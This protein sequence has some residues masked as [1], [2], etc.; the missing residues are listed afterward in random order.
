[1]HN[2]L[3]PSRSCQRDPPPRSCLPRRHHSRHRNTSPRPRLAPRPAAPAAQRPPR[4]LPLRLRK[5]TRRAA[6]ARVHDGAS[7]RLAR[8]RTLLTARRAMAA[9]PD[10]FEAAVLICLNPQAHAPESRAHALAITASV[11]DSPRAADFAVARLVPQA[12]PELLFWLLQLLHGAVADYLRGGGGSGEGEG[13]G[14]GAGAG[15]G[16]GRGTVNGGGVAQSPPPPA[17]SRPAVLAFARAITTTHAASHPQ[18]P[19]V[20]NKLA[21]LLAAHVAAEYPA[22][23]PGAMREVVLPLAA[24]AAVRTPETLDLFFRVMRALDAEVT[25]IGAAQASARARAVSVRVKDAIRDDCAPALVQLLATLVNVP[26]YAEHAYDLLARYV[27]WLDIGMFTND[28]FLPAIYAA[29]TAAGPSPRRA[30][31]A[32]AL[33]AIVNK[34]MPMVAK[35]ALLQHLQI[36]QLLASFPQSIPEDDDPAEGV[37]QEKLSAA[38]LTIQSGRHESAVLVNCIAAFALDSLRT[39]IPGTAAGKKEPPPPDPQATLEAT[40]AIAEAA[41]PL[42]LRFV[43][44][45]MGETVSQEALKCVTAYINVFGRLNVAEASAEATGKGAPPPTAAA[46]SENMWARGRE[47]LVATLNVI[48]ERA[49]FPPDYDPTDE[50]HPF[51]GLRKVLLNSVVRGIARANPSV[52]LSFVRR[53]AVHPSTATSVPRTEMV[54]AL[55]SILA[56]TALETPGLTEV[57][58]L[59]IANPPQLGAATPD[60]TT[61][62][63][64]QLEAVQIAHL[65]LVVRVYRLL[66]L[67]PDPA[68]LAAALAPFFDARGLQNPSS[69]A[70]RSRAVYLLLRL[71]RPLRASISGRHL[72]DVMSVIRPLMLPVHPYNTG[73]LFSDQMMFYEI[74]GLLVGTDSSSPASINYLGALLQALVEA[75]RAATVVEQQVAIVSAAGQLSKGFGSEAP[76]S[77]LGL[78]GSLEGSPPVSPGGPYPGV[79]QNG[80]GGGS[81][82]ANGGDI[83]SAAAAEVKIQKPKPVSDQSLQM[84]TSALEAILAAVGLM[85]PE[86]SVLTVA[87]VGMDP[88]LREK[89]VFILHRMVDTMGVTSIPYLGAV[90]PVLTKSSSSVAELRAVVVLVSQAAAKFGKSF[91]NVITALLGDLVTRVFQFPSS[92]DP[93]TMCAMSEEERERVELR[94]AYVYFV[95]VLLSAEIPIVFTAEQNAA[96]VPGIVLSL[97]DA[98]I[99]KDVDV[100]AAPTMMKMC[101]GSIGKMVGFWITPTGSDVLAAGFGSVNGQPRGFTQYL[102]D[103]VAPALVRSCVDSNLFRS[104]DLANG[105]CVSVLGENVSLQRACAL[106]IGP[107]FGQAL[108]TRGFG[109]LPAAQQQN[110][111]TYVSSLYESSVPQQTLVNMFTTLVWQVRGAPG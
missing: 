66:V 34:R 32:Y 38:E 11:R 19:Y 65:E 68:V 48:E 8:P 92:I 62:A 80:G 18:P 90:L 84:W 94:K 4:A 37:S 72:D 107:P 25:S 3:H 30:A 111:V 99:G 44:D 17:A 96:M 9:P 28:A 63:A 91:T 86:C 101:M 100:R 26:A 21:Q 46:S 82:K 47:G 23:W 6:A 14:V 5:P 75:L 105:G 41:L 42:A 87:P 78:G 109:S 10:D 54:L 29:I 51:Q 45:D 2:N 70:V 89:A 33:R 7:S 77:V 55:L 16:G 85:G 102:V 64:R 50:E 13:G 35:L 71:T 59:E 57:L 61:A 108:Q 52:V 15:A 67:S 110:V 1:M 12:R 36:L 104:G 43:S 49:C 74:A 69:P 27:E 53:I 83:H 76:S 93:G 24:D 88:T 56:E 95:H 81:K 79:S 106:R 73:Q 39:L 98:V 20:R 103:E 40:S 97:V 22:A 60:M 58:L 31:S